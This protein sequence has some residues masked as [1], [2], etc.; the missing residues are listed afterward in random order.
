M[1]NISLITAGAICAVLTTLSFVVGVAFSAGSGVQTIIPD[2]GQDAIDWINDVDDG[3][4][5]FLVGAWFVILGGFLGLLALI[6]FWEAFRDA[7]RLLILAPILAVVGFTL[8]QISHLIPIAMAY[9]LVPDYVDATGATKDSIA[10]TAD[11]FAV[12]ALVLN[13]AG[14]V[15]L[16]GVV[17]PMYAYA[18][19]K[20]RVV[21]RWIGW[22][23]FVVAFFAGW[24]GLLAPA[25][26]VI[27]GLTF[28]G[29]VGFF[30]WM[31]A[32]GVSLL[33]GQRAAASKMPA[34][35]SP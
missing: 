26:D 9:E 14:D 3:R 7:G 5:P 22:L 35:A 10:S 33:L 15:L 21:G 27:D 19:L 18:A 6:G 12:L 1:R 20:T 32:M 13:Y 2:T 11:M 23:G 16:W 30:V 17:V 29:F 4:G 28:I 31:A 24:L 34:P 8:V 25:S